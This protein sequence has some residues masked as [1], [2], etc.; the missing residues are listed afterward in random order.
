MI[1]MLYTVVPLERIYKSR[2]DDKLQ[3]PTKDLEYKEILMPHGRVLARREGDCYLVDRVLS[4][5]MSDYLKEDLY[6]GK[7]I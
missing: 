2:M 5:D 6:P 4:T 1:N 7:F 3:N